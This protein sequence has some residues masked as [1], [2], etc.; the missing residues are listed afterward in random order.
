MSSAVALAPAAPAAAVSVDA[1]CDYLCATGDHKKAYT[2]LNKR[3][4]EEQSKPSL[5]REEMVR[6]GLFLKECLSSSDSTLKTEFKF[7]NELATWDKYQLE[8][9]HCWI[10]SCIGHFTPNIGLA[11]S[12]SDDRR[13][14]KIA[15]ND[16]PSGTSRH[17]I[18]DFQMEI[19]DLVESGDDEDDDGD[20]LFFYYYLP[21]IPFDYYKP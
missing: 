1:L 4:I 6:Y 14:V 15:R 2:L 21:F 11:F 10:V 9:M 18:E 19:D 20:C 7:A 5:V 3:A 13:T 12:Y 17:E 8:T 16:K